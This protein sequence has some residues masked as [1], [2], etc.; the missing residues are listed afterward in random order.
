MPQTDRDGH[1]DPPSFL[2]FFLP[3]SFP[4]GADDI[5]IKEGSFDLPLLI[6]LFLF[7]TL[8]LT[9]HLSSLVLYN[10]GLAFLLIRC[11]HQSPREYRDLLTA[12]R[13]ALRLRSGPGLG[14]GFVL[15]TH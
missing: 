7:L 10:C 2:P 12:L 5:L 1:A 15:V 3:S 8:T 11:A 13:A 9:A 6:F 14:L 4:S